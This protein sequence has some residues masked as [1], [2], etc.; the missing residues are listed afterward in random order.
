MSGYTYAIV[1]D[2]YNERVDLV[3]RVVIDEFIANLGVRD[4]QLFRVAGYYIDV[5][6]VAEDLVRLQVLMYQLEKELDTTSRNLL[7]AS[8]QKSPKYGTIQLAMETA[9]DA[10]V[11]AHSI[12]N[13]V[14]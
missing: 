12:G 2:Y 4:Q 5:D 11:Q 6:L 3:T 1:Q 14:R 13:A 7:S 8:L 10:W 9:L